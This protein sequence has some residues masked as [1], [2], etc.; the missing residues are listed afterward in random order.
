ML[1]EILLPSGYSESLPAEMVLDNAEAGDEVLVKV[2]KGAQQPLNFLPLS[3]K[4]ISLKISAYGTVVDHIIV[5]N[6]PSLRSQGPECKNG[7][8]S[9]F[10]GIQDVTLRTFQAHHAQGDGLRVSKCGAVILI[11]PKIHHNGESGFE[12]SECNHVEVHQGEFWDNNVVGHSEGKIGWDRG[13]M[14]AWRCKDVFV[15]NTYFHD[16]LAGAALWADGLCERVHVVESR[17]KHCFGTAIHAEI[18]TE[19]VKIRGGLVENCGYGYPEAKDWEYATFDGIRIDSV[20][21]TS[22]VGLTMNA[23]MRYPVYVANTGRENLQT[24]RV[25][26][27]GGYGVQVYVPKWLEPKPIVTG[28]PMHEV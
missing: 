14:K 4:G 11:Y 26:V 13:E 19:S 28:A 20:P 7:E 15:F 6:V 27:E 2:P 17:F 1:R 18:V 8:T 25:Y 12:P 9:I 3:G 21:E 5:R 10:S 24:S 22:I 16:S 23:N